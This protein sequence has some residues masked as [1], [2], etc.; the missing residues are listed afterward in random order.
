VPT[1]FWWGNLEQRKHFEELE[2][3][4]VIILKFAFKEYGGGR[5]VSG[6]GL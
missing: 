1:E 5:G 4:G 6:S 2:V 3:D